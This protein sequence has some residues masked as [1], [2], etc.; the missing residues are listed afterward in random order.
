MFDE[1]SAEDLTVMQAFKTGEMVVGPGAQLF[2]EGAHTPQLY[3]VLAGMGLRY[4]TTADGQRQVINFVMPGDF[5]GL[6]A[7]VMG[8]MSHAVEAATEMTLCV[9][10]RADVWRIFKTNPQRAFDL[11]Y[12]AAM[13]E[14]LLGDALSRLGQHGAMEKIAW[15]LHRIFSRALAVDMVSEDNRCALPFK[16]QDL[17][18]ALGLSLVHTN[19]TLA[20]LR[21]DGVATWT[22]G[23]LHI[24]DLD[25]LGELGLVDKEKV[26]KRPLI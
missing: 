19:K 20:K 3:T 8:E 10:N 6:Q 26:E 7:G 24:P 12:L 22:A 5:L 21:A 4:K 23:Q 25:R 16:Q 11:T 15:S 2:V 17:A 1:F 18:D 9:F 13:E 14:H